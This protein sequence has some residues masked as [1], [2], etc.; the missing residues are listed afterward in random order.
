M[1]HSLQGRRRN[2]SHSG[3]YGEYFNHAQPYQVLGSPYPVG[4]SLEI[5]RWQGGRLCPDRSWVVCLTITTGKRGKV[6]QA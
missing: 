3:Y 5:A 1:P 2:L 6:G 4:E